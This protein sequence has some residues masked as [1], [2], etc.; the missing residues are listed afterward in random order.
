VGRVYDNSMPGV[1]R[2]DGRPASS[3][4]ACW[5]TG[6]LRL[7]GPAAMQQSLEVMLSTP[8]SLLLV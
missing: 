5:M 1:G 3:S 2:T 4:N 7:H 8:P 6:A